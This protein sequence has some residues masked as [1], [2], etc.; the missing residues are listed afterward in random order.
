MGPVPQR[1]IVELEFFE[2]QIKIYLQPIVPL[3]FH[4]KGS[5]G[6]LSQSILHIGYKFVYVSFIFDLIAEAF[7]IGFT[8][9]PEASYSFDP[10]GC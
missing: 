6:R 8:F 3:W 1:M 2:L 7:V 4:A 5:H 9:V 10:G